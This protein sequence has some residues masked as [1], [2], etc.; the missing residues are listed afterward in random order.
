M[1]EKL[2]TELYYQ[3]NKGGKLEFVPASKVESDPVLS[4]QISDASGKY[5]KVLG[6]FNT[7][8][9]DKASRDAWFDS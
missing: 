4:R 3:V 6:A 2:S 5:R 7:F 9:Q 1:A 8:R